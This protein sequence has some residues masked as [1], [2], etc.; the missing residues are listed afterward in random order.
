MHQSFVSSMAI[1]I[2]I[3]K[4][5]S[6]LIKPSVQTLPTLSHYKLG[7]I[8]ELALDH[9]VG[10]VLF[11]AANSNHN[12][13]SFAQLEKSLGKILTRL[14]PLA[15]RYVEETHS[16]ECKDQGVEFIHAKVNVKLQ[17]FLVSEENVKFIDEFIP[18][19]IGVA[20][21][22]SDPLLATQVTTYICG[23]VA[24]GVNATHKIV[25]A[26]TLCTFVSEW[27]VMNR[28]ENE[29]E[30]KGPGFNSSILFPGRGLSS[31]P[32]PIINIELLTKKKLSFSGSAISK[33]K[34]KGTTNSTNQWSKV[35]L[36]SAIIWK[37]F[38]GVDLA[39]HNL[40]RDSILVQAV[41][42][43]GK[44]ASLIPKTSCGNLFGLCTTECTTLER[45]EELADRLSDS[46][47]KTLTNYSK[48]HHDCEE[49]QAMV[50]NS[51]I[52]MTNISE[53]TNV[54]FT[55]SW[56]KFPFYEADFGFG[57]P[58]WVAPSMTPVHQLAYMIDDAEGTGVE[59]YVCLEVKEVPY[60]EEALE[61]AIAFGA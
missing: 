51:I 44:M 34:A 2:T 12:P 23:G 42:L 26:S 54:V 61:Q 59:A 8:D 58:I 15:G 13:N 57:K 19:K 46:V 37:T 17:D 48:A 20:R 7:F 10:V 21:Q 4:Q 22:Q 45:A 38:M 24:I 43:R 53:Y 16:V 55:T 25:D 60:F 30:F 29:I 18:S 52:S 33:M 41:N 39:K 3:E 31:M 27:A 11:F 9:D 5:S 36:V 6:K 50:L 1:A 40:Q 32:C 14:Y 28:E 35:Q 56:C 49:G 47:K